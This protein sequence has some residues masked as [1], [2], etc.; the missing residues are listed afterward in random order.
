MRRSAPQY[1]VA[2]TGLNATDDPNPGINVIRS[3]REKEGWWG[4]LKIIGLA[5]DAL[6]TG[7]YSPDLV[8]EVYL[9][10]Y[11]SQGAASLLHRMR[12]IRQRTPID[13][14]IPTL[15]G[16]LLNFC[17]A[18]PV[19]STMGIRLLLPAEDQLK[20]HFKHA[21][22]EFCEAH[23]I[24][25]PRTL[26][27]HES[28]QLEEAVKFLGFPLVLKGI[29]HEAHVTRT[30]SQAQAYSEVIRANWGLP[31]LAQEYI[32]GEG[33][34]VIALC[35]TKSRPQGMVAMKKLGVTDKGKA[36]AGVTVRDEEL[37][38]LSERIL[39]EMKWVGPAELEF[40][41][42]AESGK[43]YLLEIN[44][45]F[46]TWVYLASR[47]GQNLPVMAVQLAMG[48]A[49]RRFDSYHEGV[50]YVRHA[51]DIICSVD[52]LAQVSSHGELVLHKN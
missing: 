33:G 1:S 28:A 9:L 35:D 6:D 15:D 20:L 50:I 46:P 32:P 44:P 5:Y 36:W 51:Q 3:L 7:I 12:E 23:D 45:R 31:L 11:A 38:K 19:L 42:H 34:G 18:E 47:A 17:R 21:L 40:V 49:V 24:P 16:E 52:Q 2:V 10:P 8:D 48:L 22:S 39:R 13:V 30:L 25:T 43:P 14:V 37:L 41:R 26:L 29:L 4:K 27:I